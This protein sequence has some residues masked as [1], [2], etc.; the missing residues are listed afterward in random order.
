MA[1]KSKGTT[2]A[3]RRFQRFARRASLLAIFAIV[4]PILWFA[5]GYAYQVIRTDRESDVL[6][7][8]GSLIESFYLVAHTSDLIDPSHRLPLFKWGPDV[9]VYY[10]Q[11]LP[12]WYRRRTER[13]F[14]VLSKY[15]GIRF[16]ETEQFDQ[17]AGISV[18]YAAPGMTAG[19]MARTFGFDYDRVRLSTCYGIYERG[20]EGTTVWGHIVFSLPEG[21]RQAESCIVEETVQVMGLPADRATYFPT[22]FSDTRARPVRLP[23]NDKILL[24][25]LYDPTIK[26]G[27]TFAQTQ[28]LI[29]GIIRGLAAGV[30]ARG[31]QALY[32]D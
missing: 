1:L 3:A 17:N 22:I 25:A 32:Q 6:A 12:D 11:S 28:N 2:R 8:E 16:H 23:L 30:K 26:S 19:E 21:E 20:D 10:H 9:S 7:P 18:F 5:G 24:R 15:T 13:Q 14:E 31:E 4:A 27:M 29:P